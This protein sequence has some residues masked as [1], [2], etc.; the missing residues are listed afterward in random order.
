[1]V[2]DVIFGQSHLTFFVNWPMS[3]RVRSAIAIA[4]LIALAGSA[5]AAGFFTNDFVESNLGAE[6]SFRRSRAFNLFWEAWDRVE[7][8]FYGELPSV[9]GMTYSAIRGAFAALN[10]PYTIFIEPAAR[11]EERQSLEGTFGGIGAYLRRPE[12]GGPILLDPIPGNPAEIAGI[13]PGD[14]LL[15]VDGVAI[16]AETSVAE[17]RELVRGEKGTTVTLT[18]LH[19]GGTSPVEVVVPRDDILIP[20]VSFRILTDQRIGY[21]QLT[22]FSGESSGEVRDAIEA[23]TEQGI[24]FLILDL[25]D[26]GGGLLDAAVDVS[27]LFLSGGPILYQQRQGETDRLFEANEETLLPVTPLAL[28]INGGTASASEIVA[29]A[30]QDRQRATLIGSRSFGKGSVQLVYDLSD[31]SS[32]HVTSARWFTPDRQPIDQE[33]IQPDIPVAITQEAIENGRD[34]ILDRAVQFFQSGE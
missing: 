26:N 13:L 21:L 25:R 31:G 30:L 14:V 24:E 29:G 32:I 20:S 3:E 12:D 33:G 18:V 11:D 2:L 5:F 15:A 28:L 23:L 19:E 10:D 1:M 6:R 22:R 17:V 4:M 16:T 34:E 27:D 9:Q 8:D 7:E